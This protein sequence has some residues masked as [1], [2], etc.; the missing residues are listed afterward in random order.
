M[1]IL[2]KIIDYIYNQ[3]TEYV[4]NVLSEY[5]IEM[6]FNEF[7]DN[8]VDM[9]NDDF[10]CCITFF[11]DLITC[12]WL[13]SE[14]QHKEYVSSIKKHDFI[15]RMFKIYNKLDANKKH[16][17]IT[18]LGRGGYKNEIPRMMDK[19]EYELNINP[20]VCRSIIAEISWL[21]KKML[22]KLCDIFLLHENYVF[23]LMILEEFKIQ[24]PVLT[25]S[26][27][28]KIVKKVS[29]LLDDSNL[30]V[31]HEAQLLLDLFF[32][33]KEFCSVF[34]K[35]ENEF[36]KNNNDITDINKIAKN[37]LSNRLTPA[38]T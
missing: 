37:I 9:S 13:T 33:G 22:F 36:Y 7:L 17:F 6:I 23:K 29:P 24:Y 1:K 38:S 32:K 3:N 12:R 31:Q 26:Q 28:Q 2:K 18:F 8:C 34:W 14:K 5:P 16:N 27:R 20:F 15:G 11:T 35:I 25:K 21:D 30:F 4:Q 19:L 10:S